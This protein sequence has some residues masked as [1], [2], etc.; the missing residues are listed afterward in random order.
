MGPGL[1]LPPG[2]DDGAAAAADHVVEPP[3]RLGVDR[4]ADGAEQAQAGQVVLVAPLTAGLHEGADGRGGGVED[5]DLVAGHDV[6]EA[7]VVG[8]VG[9]TLVHERGGPVAQRAVDDVAV[10]GDPAD[11]GGAPVDVVVLD[12]E[13]AAGGEVDAGQVAGGGVDD[14]LGLAGGAAGVED[15][16]QVFGVGR[17]GPA[18]VRLA[19]DGVVPPHVAALDHVHRRAGPLEHDHLLD[20][21]DL[22]DGTVDV[23][24]ER[25]GTAAAVA[26]VGGDDEAALG[27]LQ[28]VG[29]RLAGEPAEDDR[30]GRADAGAG[31]H[32]HGRLGHV[33]QVDRHAVAPPHAQCL[34]AVGQ[35]AH[36]GQ[37]LAVGDLANLRAAAG[38]R[39]ALP[40]DG[41]LV[42][43]ALVD[44]HVQAVL[45]HVQLAVDEPLGVGR[46]PL[47]HAVERLAPAERLGHVGPEGVG[48]VDRLAVLPAVVIHRLHAGRGGER[49]RRGIGA[50]GLRFDPV[51]H[52]IPPTRR[53]SR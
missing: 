1:G 22:G 25:D 13:D 38:D 47:Q 28:A 8:E 7:A 41:G 43:A 11:V 4:F 34:E 30:V 14:A 16:E 46:V 48:V 10:A 39:L 17:L 6:P 50:D 18:G 20:P 37:Q 44:L 2:V 49:R 19:G 53:I 40:Q 21:A 23:G 36:V 45:G 35:P 51:G 32:G 29:D 15:E 52:A 5:G 31:Q 42:A 12:V 9:G 26:A 24:L 3:P 33:G 27:V